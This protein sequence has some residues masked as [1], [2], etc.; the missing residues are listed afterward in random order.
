[1]G[2]TLQHNS[3]N[4]S[5]M[6]FIKKVSVFL[7]ALS[8]LAVCSLAI[9]QPMFASNYTHRLIA[10]L[11][12]HSDVFPTQLWVKIPQLNSLT[13]QPLSLNQIS[14]NLAQTWLNSSNSHQENTLISGCNCP[15]CQGLI[16]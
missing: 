11:M 15:Q 14:G 3:L 5:P 6:K 1:M 8:V 7:L 9:A 16:V 4:N 10:E 13:N 2:K 12:P